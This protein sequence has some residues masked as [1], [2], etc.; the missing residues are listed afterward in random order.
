M[1]QQRLHQQYFL[2]DTRGYKLMRKLYHRYLD[3]FAPHF[4]EFEDFSNHIFVQVSG[5]DLSEVKNETHYIIRAI[6]LQGR[7]A[8][9]QA[10][11]KKNQQ[12]ARNLSEEGTSP[13][14]GEKTR[15]SSPQELLEFEEMLNLVYRFRQ[16]LPVQRQ[17]IFNGLIDERS[18][19]ELAQELALNENTLYSEIRR[20]R[21]KFARF[22][23]GVDQESQYGK[24]YSSN[25]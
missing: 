20:I 4:P 5:I 7:K 3:L 12:T 14:Q 6:N 16:N 18:K 22:L 25:I 15:E 23:K 9:D 19:K 13:V 10:I 17:K 21:L 11:R 24:R 8:M 2:P 1:D